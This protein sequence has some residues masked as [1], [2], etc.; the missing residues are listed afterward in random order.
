MPG[1]DATEVFQIRASFHGKT[2]DS[3]GICISHVNW[4]KNDYEEAVG[5]K[6]QHDLQLKGGFQPE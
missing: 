2:E 4:E 1:L 5:K 3:R 6:N